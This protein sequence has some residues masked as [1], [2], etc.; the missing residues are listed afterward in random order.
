VALVG[1]SGS[2]KSTVVQLIERFYDPAAGCVLLDG[3]DI[4]SLKLRWLRS[5]VGL[6]SQ[7]RPGP[8][9]SS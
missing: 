6:V 8:V 4:R 9:R 7:V 5:Q 2:G 3:V 1:S